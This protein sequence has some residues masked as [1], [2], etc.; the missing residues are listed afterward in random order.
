MK[1]NIIEVDN[2]DMQGISRRNFLSNTAL[3]AAGLVVGQSLLASCKPK[4]AN[5]SASDDASPKPIGTR[6]LGSL[7]VSTIGLGCL[8]MVGFYGNGTFDKAEMGKVI[9]EAHDNG[10]TFFDTA[11]VYGPFVD[12]EI[13]GAAVKTFRKDI[14]IATKFGFELEPDSPNKGGINSRP[15]HIKKV[16]EGSLKRL[17]TDYI[18]LLYQHR[19]D[20]NVPIEDV[21][22]AI[23]D[24][25]NAGKVL[26]WGLSEPGV[27]TIR[28]AHATH[29][30]TAIQNEYS[31]WTLNPEATVLPLCEELGIGFVP[32]CPLGYGFFAGAI[33]E[34][35]RFS[36]PDYRA[37]LPR[38]TPENLK[39]NLKVFE[40][41]KDWANRKSVT[42]AQVSLAWLLA[43]KPFIVPIP[44]TTKT[45]HMKENI[46]AAD[47]S[48]TPE[49]LKQFETDIS[50]FKIEGERNSK[51]GL[52][53]MGVEAPPK[54]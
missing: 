19:V 29:P 37:L 45:A 47:V 48:F 33:N 16:V 53:S 10:V 6:K 23:K 31:I 46:K 14:V 54:L 42:P 15:E 38:L 34:S 17:Q 8:P 25:V 4:T 21:A 30:L 50:K 3:A 49:E 35:S 43:T 39:L 27:N 22:G 32:W 2:K 18:D 20:P 44:G 36:Q 24:L 13:L 1:K 51:S 9:R 41:V 5:T 26:H 28:R 11:E 7:Q 12:E 52:A 40:V